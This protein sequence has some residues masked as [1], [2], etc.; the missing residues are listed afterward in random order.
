LK[1]FDIVIIGGG[2]I[3]L[4]TAYKLLEIKSDLRLC[5]LEK[6]S[7]IAMHQT[8]NN[9]DVIHSGIYY[10]PGSLKALNCTKGYKLLLDFC[11]RENI[12]YDLCGKM[13]IACDEVE[14]NRLSDLY[15]RG[16][17]NGLGKLRLIEKDKLKE[18]EPNV[19]G[20]KAIH[21]PYTGIV[22]FKVVSEKIAQKIQEKGGVLNC[23]EKVF[24]IIT[25]NINEIITQNSI[26]KGKVVINCG[27]LYSDAL[28]KLT[29]KN[30]MP[31]RIIPFKGEYY[32]LKKEKNDIINSLIYPVPDPAFPFL[33]VHFTRKINGGVEAGPNAVLAFK[34]EGYNKND[35]SLEDTF[36]IFTWPGFYDMATKY[37]RT[38]FEEFY[39]SYS[40][41]AFVK[42]LR[43]LIPSI[44]E[45]D[46]A[47]GGAGVRAQ[48]C[49]RDGKLL[50]DFL[51]IKEN[52]I[53]NVCNAPS[54]AATS[55]L[56]IGEHISEI[57]NELIN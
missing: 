20:V 31:F 36:E 7:G 18:L 35:Y 47:E 28:T 30:R 53:I 22:D 13:I 51:I 38:G 46:L 12:H 57:A 24:K 29:Y 43:W 1:D 14:I 40:K 16:L 4:A 32:L 19:E 33:G 34:K 17:A 5:V 15:E 27:G 6:E 8:G 45:D 21:V 25:N 10:K 49:S 42:A 44:T 3:G 26:Y 2:I 50:D 55:S 48:A 56:A 23:N 52:N 37:W 9:S 39:R 11:D 41:K 54:P